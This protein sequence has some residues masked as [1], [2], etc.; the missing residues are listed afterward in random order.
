M[1]LTTEKKAKG[2]CRPLYTFFSQ[3]Y[4]KIIFA[5]ISSPLPP[6][7]TISKIPYPILLM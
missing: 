2:N 6:F 3:L 4:K 5:L 7:N 1:T